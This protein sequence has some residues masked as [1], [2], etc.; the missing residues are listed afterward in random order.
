LPSTHLNRRQ[1]I[2][3]AIGTSPALAA[4]PARSR[5]R[6]PNILVICSDEHN[7]GVTGCYGNQIARTPHLDGLADRGV[8]FD[9]CYT[10]SPLCV[11]S[12]LSLTA[13][14]YIHRIAAWNNDT[15][16]PSDGYPSLPRILNAAGYQSFLCGKQHYDIR[17]RYGFT[18]I[19]GNMNTNRMAGRGNRRKADDESVK[20]KQAQ[21]RFRDFRVG[22]DSHIIEHDRRVTAGVLDF[23]SPRSRADK[24]FFLF[25][26]YLAPHFPL[27]VPERYWSHYKGRIPMPEIPSGFL[28]SLPLNYKH[29]RRGFGVV[30]VHPDI[31]RLGR[32]LYYG[33]T[34]WID[35]EIGK[36]LE[37]L[38]KSPVGRDTVVI[39]TSD[40][41][42]NMGNH[43]LWWKNCMYEQASRVPLLVSWAERWKA[44]GRRSGACSLVDMVRTVA[45]IGGAETPGDWD[46][47]S[48][49]RWL[50]DPNFRWKDVAV[51]Q[52]YAHNIASGYAM[53]RT[54]DWKYVYHCSPDERHPSERELYDLRSD[55]G[56][57][58]NLATEVRQKPRIG[59]LHRQ[60]LTELGEDPEES[61]RRCRADYARG[62]PDAAPRQGQAG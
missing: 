22:E 55:P 53:I 19:G 43:G 28:D 29:L 18:E 58:Q 30:D 5:E 17:H 49:V 15:R 27:I 8:V 6:Q 46:G 39:Y 31:V 57:F 14:K 26:G 54:G 42:E 16:L 50:D 1:F 11:P 59:T 21:D 10:N 23:L 52:Y 56:E 7:H 3:T 41:G 25:A 36:V 62:Y 60:L 51:S 38:R 9:G 47:T 24:P 61:E 44:G 32:E 13:G 45:E 20:L 33:F 4:Q 37:A 35:A 12:R 34:E 48:M 2:S 40:H